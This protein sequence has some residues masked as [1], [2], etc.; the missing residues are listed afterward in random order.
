MHRNGIAD[1]GPESGLQDE[2]VSM[3]ALTIAGAA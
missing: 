1:A 3:S 2:E